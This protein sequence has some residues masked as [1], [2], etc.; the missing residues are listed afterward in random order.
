MRQGAPED[1][2]RLHRDHDR[3]RGRE[4]RRRSTTAASRPPA[5]ACFL[6]AA[7]QAGLRRSRTSARTAS[8]TAPATTEGSFLNIAGDDAKNSYRHGRR[9]RRLPGQG[10]RSTPALQGRVRRR[11][12]AR[13]SAPG[14]ACARSSSRPSSAPSRP[15]RPT[16][17]RSARASAPRRSTRPTRSRPSSAT[18]NVRRERRH[19]PADH[20]VL[21]VRRGRQGGS[22]NWVFKE[23]L[24]LRP[25]KSPATGR[26]GRGPAGPRP[27][28]PSALDRDQRDG[29]P[30]DDA[31]R[32]S[33]TPRLDPSRRCASSA[34]C[35]LAI[36]VHRRPRVTVASGVLGRPRSSSSTR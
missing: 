4:P 31:P 14:Y 8:S 36:V 28:A 3:R 26:I 35:L 17:P 32:A 15:A 16:W 34:S 23:Q 11:R 12:R 18:F 27:L 24:E 6:K 1:D 2:H 33:A 20:L 5:A 30:H 13:Y 9:D 22:A 19:H 21:H 10:G 29:R 25:S 7:V